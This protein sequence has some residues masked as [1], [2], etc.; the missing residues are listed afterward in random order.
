MC[1]VGQVS[2]RFHSFFDEKVEGHPY[3]MNTQGN[4]SLDDGVPTTFRCRPEDVAPEDEVLRGLLGRFV[5]LEGSTCEVKARLDEARRRRM[6]GDSGVVSDSVAA[7]V[8]LCGT[9]SFQ[10]STSISFG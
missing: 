6:L 1:N 8:S 2:Y 10:L 3:F 5:T 9:S 4:A 7:D